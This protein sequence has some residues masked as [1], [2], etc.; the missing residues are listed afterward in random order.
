M[1]VRYSTSGNLYFSSSRPNRWPYR[2]KQQESVW[3]RLLCR[4]HRAKIKRVVQLRH[5]WPGRASS[6]RP[7]HAT[8]IGAFWTPLLIRMAAKQHEKARGTDSAWTECGQQNGA[9]VSPSVYPSS[10]ASISPECSVIHSSVSLLHTMFISHQKSRLDR[11]SGK[12]YSS[13]GGI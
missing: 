10:A 4:F 6:G 9:G 12:Q 11:T 7:F 5:L 13:Y 8:S 3:R 1:N 2:R